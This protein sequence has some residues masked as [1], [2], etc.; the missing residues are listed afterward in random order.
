M[1]PL[2]P[3]RSLLNGRRPGVNWISCAPHRPPLRRPLRTPCSMALP[4]LNS[5][6]GIVAELP[7]PDFATPTLAEPLRLP[8]RSRFSGIAKDRPLHA[9]CAPAKRGCRTTVRLSKLLPAV[10]HLKS[11][12]TRDAGFQAAGALRICG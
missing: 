4:P 2:S 12:L 10:Y 9:P 1:P 5:R 11:L 3:K 6:V 7:S 8:E